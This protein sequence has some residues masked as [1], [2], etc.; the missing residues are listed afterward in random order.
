[1]HSLISVIIKGKSEDDSLK[2]AQI[3]IKD[4]CI[5]QGFNYAV[6]MDEKKS[7][8]FGEKYLMGEI[9]AFDKIGENIKKN[10]DDYV[11]RKP[12]F[13]KDR[14]KP[15][16]DS[17]EMQIKSLYPVDESIRV[18]AYCLDK[19]MQEKKL[20]FP[21]RFYDYN[22][23]PMLTRND[24]INLGRRM[25]KMRDSLYSFYLVPV[26]IHFESSRQ[27]MRYISREFTEQNPE[28]KDKTSIS[29]DVYIDDAIKEGTRIIEEEEIRK[30]TN[31]KVSMK[32]PK[33]TG[34]KGGKNV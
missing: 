12:E 24:V 1:M 32:I 17:L 21:P 23:K 15:V 8:V 25:K 13:G 9:I 33:G 3:L 7:I 30:K 4:I 2:K 34:K 20:G 5:K 22:G 29:G 18:A 16:F 26:D 31:K 10:D 11:F 27:Q 28:F 6:L 19:N 14:Y